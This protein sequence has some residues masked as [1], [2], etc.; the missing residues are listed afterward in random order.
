MEERTGDLRD[1]RRRQREAELTDSLV[2]RPGVVARWAEI[3]FFSDRDGNGEI[4][5]MNADG[6]EQR[7]LT[8]GPGDV[9]TPVGRPTGR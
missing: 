5:V 1:E 6:S 3:V 2:L 4:Y 8:R 9:G 7:R